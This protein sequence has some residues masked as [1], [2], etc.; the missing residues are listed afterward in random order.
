MRELPKPERNMEACATHTES[1]L[2]LRWAP[3][4]SCCST[5]VTSVWAELSSAP[6]ISAQYRRPQRVDTF[7]SSQHTVSLKAVLRG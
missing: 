2:C 1:S 3:V 7:D 5:E 4:S 6:P